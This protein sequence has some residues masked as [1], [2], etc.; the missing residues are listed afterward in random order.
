MLNSQEC[1]NAVN[2]LNRTEIKGNE[3][4]PLLVLVQ[5]LTQMGQAAF[6]QE[7]AAK[8]PKPAE[9]ETD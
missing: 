5:K 6:Q 8:D 1:Q 4:T 3:A 2:F 9:A 7:Q